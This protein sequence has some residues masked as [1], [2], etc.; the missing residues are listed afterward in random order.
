MQVRTVAV[1]GAGIMGS[2]IAQICAQ[3]GWQTRLF[4][5]FPESLEKGMKN[6]ERFWD[7]GIEKGK[8]T[9]E[10]KQEW[11]KNLKTCTDLFQAVEGVDLVIEAVPE[12]ME[13]KKEF[14]SFKNWIDANHPLSLAEWVK[15]FKKQFKFCHAHQ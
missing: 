6:I 4:D 7:K 8:T 15:L 1:I 5:P 3:K 11:S 2:G 13:L 10:E 14:G 12:I 9:I